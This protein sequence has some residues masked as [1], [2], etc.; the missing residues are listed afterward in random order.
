MTTARVLLRIAYRQDLGATLASVGKTQF[1]LRA[2]WVTLLEALYAPTPDDREWASAVANAGDAIFGVTGR[3]GVWLVS[4]PAPSQ[5]V[6]IQIAVGTAAEHALISGNQHLGVENIRRFLYPAGLVTTHQTL[7]R[8]MNAEVREALRI[9]HESF[10]SVDALGLL[11]QPKP[12]A[13]AVLFHLT[14]QPIELTPQQKRLLTQVALHFEVAWRLRLNPD[15]VRGEILPD[16]RIA[17]LAAGQ[18]DAASLSTRVRAIERVRTRRHRNELDAID[19]WTA[20]VD[21]RFSLVERSQGGR[22]RYW[23]IENPSERVPLRALTPGEV[24]VIAQAARGLSAKLIAY[25]LGISESAVSSRLADAASKVGT[26]TRTELVRIAALLA[27][28][29]RA[30]F[31]LELTDAERSVLDLVVRGLSN[32]EIAHIRNRSAR[33]IANQVASLLSKAQSPSRRALATRLL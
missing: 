11:V 26:G 27:R 5:S 28:D 13:V 4:H 32:R 18:V 14:R 17:D 30:G 19:L 3:C 2:R 16:G 7:A 23:V 10:D 12:G 1:A 20:L 33:T 15:T 22:R 8:D 24:E 9:A 21:G 6:Q 29:P 31:A 25:S